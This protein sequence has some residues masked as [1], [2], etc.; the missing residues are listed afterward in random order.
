MEHRT[1]GAPRPRIPSGS[2]R[3]V[4]FD[5]AGTIVDHGSIAP[6]DA[7]IA[8]FAHHGVTIDAATAR[9][10]MGTAK[11][12]HISA[13]LSLPA[14]AAA[15]AA[16]HGGVPP[17]A[18]SI[19]ALYADF[20]PLQVAAARG[21]SRPIPGVLPMLAHLRAAGVRTGGCSGYNTAIMA[22]VLE[23]AAA[24]GLVLE[25]NTC[26]N[27]AGSNGRP[28]P[29][30]AAEVAAALDAWPLS[31]CVKVDDTLPGIAEG[32]NAGMWTV[33]V[34]ASGNELGMDEAELAA[35]EGTP[36]L[37]ERLRAAKARFTA[38]GA[39][40][41]LRSAADLGPVIE[42]INKRIAAGESP[43]AV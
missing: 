24:E 17:D 23:G 12:E 33:G 31:A 36:E 2:V 13:I 9:G 16:A 43:L 15:W 5:W 8:V 27:A 25:A 35:A 11:R 6:V 39:H 21:R 18:S 38:A 28:K 30:M 19:D 42:D 10:P 34:T 26:G 4:I 29:W 14:V 7:F 22:A 20:T 1:S 40:Y 41:V 3:A 37:E 32:L